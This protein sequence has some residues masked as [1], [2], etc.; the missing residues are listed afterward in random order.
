MKEIQ[1]P[2]LLEEVNNTDVFE[3]FEIMDLEEKL[4]FSGWGGGCDCS[5]NGL[6]SSQD[7]EY[8]S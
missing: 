7:A 1:K 4:D 3:T 8:L 6:C 5:A 2:T